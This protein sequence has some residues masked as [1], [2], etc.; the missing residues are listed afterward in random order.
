MGEMQAR[1]VLQCWFRSCISKMKYEKMALRAFATSQGAREA[2]LELQLEDRRKL[3]LE[4]M[5]DSRKARITKGLVEAIIF[6]Q[7][8][9]R[10]KKGLAN[11]KHA[12]EYQ[13]HVQEKNLRWL[14]GQIDNVNIKTT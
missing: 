4:R 6:T 9:W 14:H 8:T 11:S 3:A 12:L 5:Q 2:L 10:K 7:E 13:K 1:I